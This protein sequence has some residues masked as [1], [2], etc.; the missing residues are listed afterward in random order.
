MPNTD[1]TQI[2]GDKISGTL[3]E[4]LRGNIQIY[5]SDERKRQSAEGCQ[6]GSPRGWGSVRRI[7]VARDKEQ[8][9]VFVKEIKANLVVPQNRGHLLRCRGD[10][11]SGSAED[12]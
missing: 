5:I 12:M 6:N 4:A 2:D 9:R 11:L 1:V 10:I 7:Q 8:W 3:R